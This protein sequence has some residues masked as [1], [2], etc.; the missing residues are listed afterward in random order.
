VGH[1]SV[2]GPQGP[3]PVPRLYEAKLKKKRKKLVCADLSLWKGQANQLISLQ[4]VSKPLSPPLNVVTAEDTA[5]AVR[6]CAE[7]IQWSRFITSKESN[8]GNSVCRI[9]MNERLMLERHLTDLA[10]EPIPFLDTGQML[11]LEVLVKS[12]RPANL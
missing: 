3:T 10:L 9:V 12:P 5:T 1:W 6:G 7:D 11:P 2:G 8:V 4:W